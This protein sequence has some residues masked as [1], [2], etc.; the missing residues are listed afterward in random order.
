M[1]VASRTRSFSLAF[2]FIEA[3]LAFI[4][5]A[6]IYTVLDPIQ[7]A[8]MNSGIWSSTTTYGQTTLGWFAD[9]WQWVMVWALFTML[10]HVYVHS[11]R[12]T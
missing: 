7:Q 12:R 9:G 10:F 4:I 3:V 8:L 11:R 1:S 6:F 5:T 2:L